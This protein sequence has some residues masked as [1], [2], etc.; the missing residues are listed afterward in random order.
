MVEAGHPMKALYLL[1]SAL[2]VS[3][4][5]APVASP[6]PSTHPKG[7]PNLKIS[8]ETSSEDRTTKQVQVDV[9]Q[10]DPPC[11]YHYLGTVKVEEHGS[12]ETSIP[13]NGELL[14][15]ANYLEAGRIANDAQNPSQLFHFT[16]EKGAIYELQVIEQD[17]HEEMSLFRI[18]ASGRV[19][20]ESQGPVPCHHLR[21]L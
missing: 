2:T 8:F 14:L 6:P 9:D 17:I 21:Q 20:V 15:R 19:K 11:G 4:S 5:S 3:C 12:E 16:P 13:E 7:R 1:L 18:G 10:V